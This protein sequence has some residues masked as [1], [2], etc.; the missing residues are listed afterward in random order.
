MNQNETPLHQIIWQRFLKVLGE[1]PA[2]SPTDAEIWAKLR[3][4]GVAILRALLV[5]TALVILFREAW[6]QVKVLWDKAWLQLPWIADHGLLLS[7]LG[8]LLLCVWIR[9]IM[10]LALIFWRFTLRHRGLPLLV[11]LTLACLGWLET[12]V[13][14][15]LASGY[16]MGY[17]IIFAL[18]FLAWQ[19]KNEEPTLQ[20]DDLRRSRIVGRLAKHLQKDN[21]TLKRIVLIGNWGSGKTQTLKLLRHQLL[22]APLPKLFLT[23]TVNPWRAQTAEEAMTIIASGFDEAIGG[24]RAYARSWIKHPLGAWFSSWKLEPGYGITMD[25]IRLI[26]GDVAGGEDRMIDKINRRLEDLK[27]ATVVIMVDDME[28]AEPEV[29]RK[30]FPVID[31]LGEIKNCF[32]VFAIDPERIAKAFGESGISTEE[33][34]GYLDKVFDLRI[35]LPKPHQEDIA[36][37]CRSK[38]EP[39]ETPKL[40]AAFDDLA[41]L[42]PANPRLALLFL[43]DAKNQEFLFLDR[44]NHKE[45]PFVPFFVYR[46]CEV[47]FSGFGQAL[48]TPRV[49]QAYEAARPTPGD[50]QS[51]NWHHNR[52][53]F[54]NCVNL[55]G[56]ALGFSDKDHDKF[57]RLRI[58]LGGLLRNACKLDVPAQE[59]DIG[60]AIDG[61][62]ILLKLTEKELAELELHWQKNAGVMSIK[63]MLETCFPEYERFESAQ[64]TKQFVMNLLGEFQQK[65]ETENI[66]LKFGGQLNPEVMIE[67]ICCFS[68]HFQFARKE[69]LPEDLST[70]SVEFIEAS[71]LILRYW[72]ADR[73]N[74]DE[75]IFDRL[76]QFHLELFECMPLADLNFWD[77]NLN[78]IERTSWN[79]G[80]ASNEPKWLKPWLTHQLVLRKAIVE[81]KNKLILEMMRQDSFRKRWSKLD[82]SEISKYQNFDFPHFWIW[83]PEE[84]WTVFMKSLQAEAIQNPAISKACAE[85]ISVRTFKDPTRRNVEQI[86]ALYFPGYNDGLWRVAMLLPHDSAIRQ[87]L[88]QERK[89]MAS[90]INASDL[91]S[92]ELFEQ[93]FPTPISA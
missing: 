28:R 11:I 4:H 15:P 48:S 27:P 70:F 88:I 26:E 44:Y 61:P 40:H 72:L 67:M 5:T 80:Y 23:A 51:K 41:D 7:V 20:D 33:T 39:N 56:E 2:P 73:F 47:E 9:W 86:L 50:I 31:R 65:V 59:F 89:N 52:G 21:V 29:V 55:L 57:A 8:L 62:A 79:Y 90:K 91:D 19:E 6:P 49:S 30:L 66:K 34:K 81:R 3:Q 17:S 60:W 46:L 43:S 12:S 38:I 84:D 71:L 18:L 10:G 77:H 63:R 75:L 45:K 32:F 24:R 53:N 35:E 16:W 37:M 68:K 42:L 83:S 82:L 69:N 76:L 58:L 74:G 93:M 22:K 87:S 78:N 1:P 54:D 92:I 13:H 64:C 25:L 14:P 85:I 36:Q